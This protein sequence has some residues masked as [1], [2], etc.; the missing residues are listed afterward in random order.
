MRNKLEIISA[1]LFLSPR[2]S[3]FS[4]INGDKQISNV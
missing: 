2:I 3:L 1:V 4:Q